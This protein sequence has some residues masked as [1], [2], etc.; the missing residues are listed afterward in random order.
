MDAHGFA[1]AEYGAVHAR[2]DPYGLDPNEAG[3][4]ALYTFECELYKRLNGKLRERDRQQLKP[5]F[6]YLKL[7]IDARRKLPKHVGMVWR[8][9]KG[10]DLR[11]KY[12]K[13]SEV[14]WWAYGSTKEL[15]TLQSPNFSEPAGCAQCSTFRCS[16]V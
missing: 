10:V 9:V 11:S 7:M 4:L 15:S 16:G 2:D 12:P 3:A 14:Y 8:R 1:A 5:F 13:G 6:P